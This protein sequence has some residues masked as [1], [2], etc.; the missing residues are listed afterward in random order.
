MAAPGG[1]PTPNPYDDRDGCNSQ[2]PNRRRASRAIS[3]GHRRESWPSLAQPCT[4][5]PWPVQAGRFAQGSLRCCGIDQFPAYL[6][7]AQCRA[8]FGNHQE[9][10]TSS[11]AST[12]A[13]ASHRT[14][15]FVLPATRRQPCRS[16]YPSDGTAAAESVAPARPSPDI[17]TITSLVRSASAAAAVTRSGSTSGPTPSPGGAKPVGATATTSRIGAARSGATTTQLTR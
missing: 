7:P 2:R 12:T 17:Q 9:F 8:L 1:S 5:P 14:L 15:A 10:L 11:P 13:S 6:R 16:I 3:A 4:A